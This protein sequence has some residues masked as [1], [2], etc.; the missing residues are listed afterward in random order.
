MSV[1][2]C[3]ISACLKSETVL[4]KWHDQKME[5]KERDSNNH[6]SRRVPR[7][8]KCSEDVLRN[9]TLMTYDFMGAA[10]SDWMRPKIE[11]AG[12]ICPAVDG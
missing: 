1:V 6:W 8:R 12:A 3:F 4:D 10:G 2:V 5:T 7:L 11:I 9:V